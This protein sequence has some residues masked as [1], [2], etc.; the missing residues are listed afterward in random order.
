M[1][2]TV[3]RRNHTLPHRTCSARLK[4]C[5]ET[6]IRQVV[7]SSNFSSWL[8]MAVSRPR[9]TCLANRLVVPNLMILM[10][11]NCTDKPF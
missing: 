3:L 5:I 8:L 9:S 6:S 7:K 11:L 2:R 4:C 10:F 1:C